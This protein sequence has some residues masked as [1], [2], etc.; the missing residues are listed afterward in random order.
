MFKKL[1]IVLVF[2]CSFFCVQGQDYS[3]LWTG[4]FSYNSIVSIAPGDREVYVASQN[5]VFSYSLSTNEIKTYSTIDGLTG[6]LIS[7]VYYSASTDILFVGYYSGLVD[8]ILPDGTVS[9]L[10]AIRDKPVIL[11]SEKAINHFYENE[12]ILHIATGFG[13]SLFDLDRLE[14]KDSYFIGDNGTRLPILQTIIFEDFIYAASPTGGLRRARAAA[15]NLIDFKNWETIDSQGWLGLQ[16]VAT[17]LFG[18][19]SD[20]TLQ[21]LSSDSFITTANFAGVPKQIS[22]NEDE[23]LI[24]F[25][26]EIQIYSSQ[27]TLKETIYTSPQY[28]SGYNTTIKFDG[29]FYVGTAQN[30]LLITSSSSIDNA[31]AIIPEGPLRNDPFNIEAAFGELWVVFGDYSDAYNPYPLKQRGVSNLREETWLNI[32][33]SELLGA[34]NITNITFNPD[35]ASQVFLS[36][37]NSGLLELNDKVPVHLYNESNSGLSDVPSNPTDVRINGAAFDVSGNL[38]MTNSL[39]KNG[40]AKKEGAVIQ[41]ISVADI[42]PDFDEIN[43]Y[44]E[45]VTDR[46][47]NVYFG[48]SNR[49]LIGYNPQSQSFIRLDESRSNLPSNAILSLV[50]DLNGSLWIGT[51]AGLRILTSPAQMFDEPDIQTRKIIIEDNGVAVELLGE[52]VIRTIAVDGNNNKWVGTVGSGA[53]YFTSNGLETLRQFGTN[54]SPLPSNNI[55]DITID[56]Q[57]G[58]VYFAT[59][60]GLVSYR[61]SAVAAKDTL[62]D[63]RV[64]PNPVRPNYSGLVTLDGLTENATIKITD[65]NGNLVYE[66]ESEGGS[67][68]WDTTAFGKYKVASGVYFIL[69]T[70]EDAVET[71]IIKLMIIR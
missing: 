62:E 5:S 33:Y 70:A 38:W 8:L 64:F 42:L 32:P 31:L 57:S 34:N 69:I 54:N 23:L 15:D 13:I 30:G 43:A 25:E 37:Y 2:V 36:S 12:D 29:A 66:E 61:G 24:T 58:E 46:R 49:G 59:A 14:F 16:Q 39:V 56:D 3:S 41:G 22:A 27:G 67:I 7:T 52:Q 50:I 6:E 68:Q 17:T 28:S 9:T 35:D 19:R 47:G 60:L 10:V 51:A 20:Q 1:L 71:K 65:L 4:H 48:T 44:T 40:L 21:Q 11:P 26:N 18:V 53:F 63:A 45:V 55:Q